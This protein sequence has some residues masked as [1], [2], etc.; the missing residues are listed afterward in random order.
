MTVTSWLAGTALSVALAQPGFAQAAVTDPTDSVEAAFN[1]PPMSARPRVWWHWMNG[2]VSAKGID[3]DLDWMARIG[4]GGVHNFD[5]GMQTPQVVKD[6]LAYMTP[7]W[8]AAF[9]QAVNKA[10]SDKLEFAIASSPGFSET[11]GPWVPPKDAMKKLVWTQTDIAGGKA[12]RLT[13]PQASDA[14]GPYQ[15]VAAQDAPVGGP[16]LYRDIGVFAFPTPPGTIERPASVTADGKVIDPAAFDGSDLDKGAPI[17]VGTPDAPGSIEITFSSPVTLRSMTVFCP[18]AAPVY[19][20]GP[21]RP[22]FEVMSPKGG[23]TRVAN[24]TL[25]A[26]P[27]TLSFT[28]TTGARFRLVFTA[29]PNDVSPTSSAAPGAIGG[30]SWTARRTDL[31]LSQLTFSSRPRVNEFQLKDGFSFLNN[32]YDI[33]T[34]AAAGDLGIKPADVINLSDHLDASGHLEWKAPAGK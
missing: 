13:L 8:K 1:S 27:I 2:N 6:R 15:G 20:S 33:G 12:I 34:G 22:T 18:G 19:D 4:I 17:S 11:G 14:S 16:R 9:R 5:I 28:P 7:A 21:L 23:W 26:V 24:V 29:N 31:R 30:K 3:E 10:S 25:A 32:Y